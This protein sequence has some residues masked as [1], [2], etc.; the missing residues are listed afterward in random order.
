MFRISEKLLTFPLYSHCNA[1]MIDMISQIAR[2]RIGVH[3]EFILKK[4]YRIRKTNICRSVPSISTVILYEF[5]EK[6]LEAYRVK[7]SNKSQNL[8][9]LHVSSR[10]RIRK[11]FFKFFSFLNCNSLGIHTRTQ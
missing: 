8:F 1:L 10:P 11:V 2:R 9:A 4:T 3:R 7:I 5:K 6:C